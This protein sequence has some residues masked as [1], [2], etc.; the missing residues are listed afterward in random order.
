MALNNGVAFLMELALAV[1]D[2][3]GSR[4]VLERY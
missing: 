4:D 2:D 1:E 3:Q